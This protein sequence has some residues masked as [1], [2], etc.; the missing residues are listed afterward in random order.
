MHQITYKSVC[1]SGRDFCESPDIFNNT[2]DIF[3]AG[4][5]KYRERMEDN[6]TS[7]TILVKSQEL[8]KADEIVSDLR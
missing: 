4:W 7:N 5:T 1:R 3:S 8:I 2:N 6:R